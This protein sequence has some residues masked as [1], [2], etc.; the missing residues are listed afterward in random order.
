MALNLPAWPGRGR[1]GRETSAGRYEPPSGHSSPGQCRHQGSGQTC[2][3]KRALPSAQAPEPRRPWVPGQRKVQLTSQE[4]PPGS[5]GTREQG[6]EL[7]PARTAAAA[8]KEGAPAAGCPGHALHPGPMRGDVPGLT[9]TA[10]VKKMPASDASFFMLKS[11]ARPTQ[12]RR[13]GPR[14][15]GS[16]RPPAA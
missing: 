6:P 5:S 7:S 2:Q 16:P 11:M 4:A 10:R 13:A 14:A 3:C 12:G 15:A 9:C 1:G 8:G